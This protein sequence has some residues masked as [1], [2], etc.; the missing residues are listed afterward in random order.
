M[1]EM[2]ETFIAHLVEL[3]DRLLRAMVA[4][5]IVFIC[6]MPWAGEIYDVLAKPMMDTLPE[7]TH[8]IATGVV[9]PFFVPVKVTMMVAFVLALPV[10]LYQAWAFVA[11]GLYAHE[12][13]L[14]IPLV[15]GS[16]LL[17]LIGMAFC[18]FFVFGTVFRFIAEFAPKSIVPAPD[19]EQYLSFV[20][21]MFIAFG[22]TFEVPVAVILLVKAGVVTVAKLR[23]IRPYVVVGAFVIAAIITPPDVISQFMLAVPMCLLY[24]LGIMLANMISKP[25]AEPDYVAPTAVEMDRE[26]DRIEDAEREGK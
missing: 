13:K 10:V 7:G 24:E 4:L 23:E 19:I 5:V 1:N 6:L 11:P 8:M 9:T 20:M 14:A 3:R 17:F 15:A 2:Q 21:S 22:L 26:L 25:A 18:Y 12:R 16:T